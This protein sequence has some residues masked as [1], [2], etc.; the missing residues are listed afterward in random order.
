MV[1]PFFRSCEYLI[2][3]IHIQLIML[4]MP[5]AIE[6]ESKKQTKFKM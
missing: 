5:S 2:N 3:G 4:I 6:N 1:W